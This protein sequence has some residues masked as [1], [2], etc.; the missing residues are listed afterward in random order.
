MMLADNEGWVLFSTERQQQR[1]ETLE[2]FQEIEEI[3]S[4]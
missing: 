2:V 4:S 1:R 3:F